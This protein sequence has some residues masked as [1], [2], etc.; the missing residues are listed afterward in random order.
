MCCD[1]PL[2]VSHN[3]SAPTGCLW[4]APWPFLFCSAY[5]YLILD[6]PSSFWAH[7]TSR[8]V[9]SYHSEFSGWGLTIKSVVWGL[10]TSA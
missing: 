1:D 10:M 9:L 8:Q 3:S 4:K 5:C 2:L 7:T 6:V